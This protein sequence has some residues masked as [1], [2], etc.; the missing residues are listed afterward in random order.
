M[1]EVPK[2]VLDTTILLQASLYP[3][4]SAGQILDC[5]RNGTAKGYLSSRLRQEYED[6]LHRPALKE[7]YPSLTDDLA[8]KILSFVY[9]YCEE[10]SVTPSY[11]SYERDRSDEPLINLCIAV[12]A[13]YLIARDRDLIDLN[14]DR[15]FNLLYPFLTIATPENFLRI[16]GIRQD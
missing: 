13:D 2:I 3:N 16:Q 7:L 5:L 8:N 14:K 12:K 1:S 15:D 10:I 4:K 9:Y 6:V 11:V